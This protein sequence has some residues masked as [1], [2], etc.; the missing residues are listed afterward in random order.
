MTSVIIRTLKVGMCAALSTVGKLLLSLSY[1]RISHKLL[2]VLRS[3]LCQQLLY[4]PTPTHPNTCCSAHTHTHNPLR[5]SSTSLNILSIRTASSTTGK[6]CGLVSKSWPFASSPTSRSHWS[7]AFHTMLAFHTMF[8]SIMY[9]C[10]S[11]MKQRLVFRA[12]L[13]M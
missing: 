13:L 3:F 6:T 9:R 1:I 12:Q 7:V 8:M 10:N 11:I 2:H 4:R 5:L